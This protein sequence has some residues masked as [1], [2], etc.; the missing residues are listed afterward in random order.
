MKPD[1]KPRTVDFTGTPSSEEGYDFHW[2]VDRETFETVAGRV[3]VPDEQIR[4]GG[5]RLYLRDVAAL[6][7]GKRRVRVKLSVSLA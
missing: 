5:Y 4:K 1:A 3:P 2:I 7:R 6:F